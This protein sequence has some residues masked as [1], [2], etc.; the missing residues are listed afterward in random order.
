MCVSHIYIILYWEWYG[1]C[2]KVIH[3]QWQKHRDYKRWPIG[4]ASQ[5]DCES[6]GFWTMA[7]QMDHRIVWNWHEL[8]I[9]GGYHFFGCPRWSSLLYCFNVQRYLAKCNLALVFTNIGAPFSHIFARTSRFDLAFSP[10]ES[11]LTQQAIPSHTQFDC[12]SRTIL[13]EQISLITDIHFIGLRF[14]SAQGLLDG[15]Q[16]GTQQA[17][18]QAHCLTSWRSLQL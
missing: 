9:I 17:S 6:S 4:W 11:R 8:T 16:G 10:N 18:A 2:S 13:A 1:Y 3:Q 12:H 14:W 15:R 5:N 7:Y